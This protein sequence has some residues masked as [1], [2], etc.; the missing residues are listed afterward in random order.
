MSRVLVKICGLTREEDVISA[1]DCG[2]DA[3]GFVFTK[4]PR[5]ITIET[6]TRLAGLVPAG[7]LRIGLFLNQNRPEIEKVIN[8]VTL[9]VLQFHGNE[10]EM[11]CLGFDLPWLKAVAM[12]DIGS[13]RQAEKDYPSAKGL[14]LDSHTPGGQGGSGKVF[15]WSLIRPLSIPVWL[16]GGLTEVN[17]A[18]AIKMVRPYA[19]D[20]SSG[21]ESAP[22]I[23]DPNKM[24]AFIKAVREIDYEPNIGSKT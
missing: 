20:V 4:S 19:V 7:V 23:K 13:A 12:T 22:G 21:V 24:A 16:A 3:I 6:A 11:D 1:V 10:T 17:V 14:L 9:D 15:D 18:E 5:Q 8:A 2:A